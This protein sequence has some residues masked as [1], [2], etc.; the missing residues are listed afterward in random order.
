M[1]PCDGLRPLAGN[2]QPAWQQRA[3]FI[4]AEWARQNS[5]DL[6]FYT[7]NGEHANFQV[8][9]T[10]KSVTD[11]YTGL[12]QT[13]SELTYDPAYCT[14]SSSPS[15]ASPPAAVCTNSQIVP[16]LVGTGADPG[17]AYVSLTDANKPRVTLSLPSPT[18]PR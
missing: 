1:G 4:L 2:P 3:D 11:Q 18:P 16:T 17:E 8:G 13:V 9:E 15:L 5:C 7:A 6:V 12:T 10:T 14:K